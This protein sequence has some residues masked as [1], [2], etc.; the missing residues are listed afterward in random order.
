MCQTLYGK[1]HKATYTHRSCLDVESHATKLP[2]H[3]LCADVNGRGEEENQ[4]LLIQQSIG[5]F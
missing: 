2:A 3:S 1:K 5:D 4:Q